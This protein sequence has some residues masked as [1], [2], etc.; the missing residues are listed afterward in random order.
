M[1]VTVS[2]WCSEAAPPRIKL[3]AT[4]DLPLVLQALSQAPF[5]PMAEATLRH[6]SFK[7]AF[8]LAITSAKRVGEL[9]ALSITPTCLRWKADYSGVTLLPNISFLPKVLSHDYINQAIE[10]EA[11]CPPPFR[12]ELEKVANLLCPIRALRLY[13]EA[14]Q[15]FRLSE[16]LFVCFSGRNKGRALSKQRLSHWVVEA[17]KQAYKAKGLSAPSDVICHSTR[18]M[19][20]SWAAMRGVSLSEICAAASWQTP[21]TF[22]RFYRLNVASEST[23][24][25]A[26][27]PLASTSSQ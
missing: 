20:T 10:L 16:Q 15:G 8:L 13:I 18:G 14:T 3:I 9:H 7:T 11:Y 24:A 27:L 22:S 2:P 12:S 6:L 26:I 23:L 17:I 25:S 4:W 5:E 19:A 21:C 1:G